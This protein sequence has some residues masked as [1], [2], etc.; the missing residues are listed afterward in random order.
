MGGRLEGKGAA[1]VVP[2][3]VPCNK[4]LSV[5]HPQD[6]GVVL[7]RSLRAAPPHEI[8]DLAHDGHEV[9]FDDEEVCRGYVAGQG[10]RGDDGVRGPRGFLGY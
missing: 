4:G 7:V 2:G 3:D 5:P 8:L 1:F 9:R 10:E 6:I